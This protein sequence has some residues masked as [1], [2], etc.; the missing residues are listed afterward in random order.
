M[1]KV[2]ENLAESVRTIKEDIDAVGDVNDQ[3]D[4]LLV[5][6]VVERGI[7]DLDN[8]K[9]AYERGSPG[10]EELME[11]INKIN[12][13]IQRLASL[14][15]R[16]MQVKGKAAEVLTAIRGLFTT[17]IMKLMNVLAKYTKLQNWSIGMGVG[18]VMITL[19]FGPGTEPRN[20]PSSIFL[21]ILQVQS[22]D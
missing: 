11:V 19:T 18:L 8:L 7:T 10:P 16:L 17:N 13:R 21:F 15:D 5:L 22:P 12:Y 3:G 14:M 9:T 2:L 6:D 1:V 4:L 20:N